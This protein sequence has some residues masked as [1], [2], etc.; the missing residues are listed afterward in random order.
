MLTEAL[1]SFMEKALTGY[2][3]LGKALHSSETQFPS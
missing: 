3:T 2:E 1:W